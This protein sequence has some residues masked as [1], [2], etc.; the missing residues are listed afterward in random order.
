MNMIFREATSKD[1]SQMLW[2]R[3]SVNENKLTDPN[4]ILAEDVVVFLNIKG[5]GWVC[6]I[7]NEVVGLAM[8]NLKE[9]NIWAL[10]V[11]P[12]HEGLGIGRQLHDMMLNWYFEQKKDKLWLGT[13]PKTRAEKFYK[14]CG[15]TNMGMH[16]DYELKFEMTYDCW[17]KLN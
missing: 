13:S 4:S 1:A 15:W 14:K 5:K 11:D 12:T 10:F 16:S 2:V 7:K 8:V 3:N 17:Q 6:E 9:C